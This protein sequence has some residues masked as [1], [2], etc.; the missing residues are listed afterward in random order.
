MVYPR[1]S[2][3]LS[4]KQGSE[5]R[6]VHGEGKPR[7]PSPVLFA[8]ALDRLQAANERLRI[9]GRSGDGKWSGLRFRVHTSVHTK[10]SQFRWR[11]WP[12]PL[13][14]EPCFLNRSQTLHRI[15]LGIATLL[16]NLVRYAPRDSEGTEIPKLMARLSELLDCP[17]FE[18]LQPTEEDQRAWRLG[19][20]DGPGNERLVSIAWLRPFPQDL[21]DG[22]RT[23]LPSAAESR[24]FEAWTVQKLQKRLSRCR[25]TLRKWAVN[26]RPPIDRRKKGQ[27]FTQEELAR[28]A[29]AAERLA[30]SD[31]AEAIRDLF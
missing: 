1:G 3:C 13:S 26:A 27:T 9:H 10:F 22:I 17:V 12:S 16:W 11:Q 24:P 8:D 15:P 29:D 28:L 6:M 21:L 4:Q 19:F 18:L 25:T 23:T 14:C 30:D 5:R 7:E 20:R 2:R 31:A